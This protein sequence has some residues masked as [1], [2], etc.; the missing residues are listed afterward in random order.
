MIIR[1]YCIALH[2]LMHGTSPEFLCVGTRGHTARK[3]FLSLRKNWILKH[4][5]ALFFGSLL[6]FAFFS[7]FCLFA[8]YGIFDFLRF[9]Y[10]FQISFV[11]SI[12]FLDFSSPF[13]FLLI[14]FYRYTFFLFNFFTTVIFFLLFFLSF[15]IKNIVF[16][17][18]TEQT[19]LQKKRKKTVHKKD[20]H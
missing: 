14:L 20:I 12:D 10:I 19:I 7:F 9:V 5:N 18:T 8:I 2:S 13:V 4:K 16:K 3:I 11:V 17:V 6:V 15:G 1:H